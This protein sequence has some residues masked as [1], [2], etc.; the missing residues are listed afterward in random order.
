MGQTMTVGVV[1]TLVGMGVVFAVLIIL[2]FT[3][4]LLN[5]IVDAIDKPKKVS[6]PA[7]APVAAKAPAAPAPAAAAGLDAKV[8]A[9]I[10]AAIVAATGTSA[11]NLKFTAIRRVGGANYPWAAAG[12]A[13]IMTNR[14]RFTE[15]G[16]R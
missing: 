3:T 1:T 12:S 2:S 7:P 13:E 4:W 9:A 5:K 10:T 11:A 15:G 8:V 14:Q 16:N 6:T